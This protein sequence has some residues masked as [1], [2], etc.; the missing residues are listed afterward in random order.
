M[1]TVESVITGTHSTI[2]L[3][4][5]KQ[6]CPQAPAVKHWDNRAEPHYFRN[7]ETLKDCICQAW[8]EGDFRQKQIIILGIDRE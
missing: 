8:Q 2:L 5:G 3:R 7:P 1:E 4:I 6:V